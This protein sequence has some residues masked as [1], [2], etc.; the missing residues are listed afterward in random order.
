MPTPL[1]ILF[2]PISITVLVLYAALMGWEALAPA[3]KLPQVT[4]WKTKGLLA[5]TA[6]F[7][8]ASYLPLFWD[9][10]LASWQLFDLTSYGLVMGTL[11]GFVV[12]ELVLYAWHRTMHNSN[13]LWRGFHQMHHSAERLDAFG[14]FWMSPMDMIGFAFIGS[15]ALALIVG[16]PPQAATNILLIT[17]FLAIFQHMN[18]KTPHW[19]G[20]VIERP[21]SHN[22]HHARGLHAFNY[23]DL[24]LID[25]AFGT[26]RNPHAFEHE[27]G[28]YDGAS[29]RVLD[30][31][32]FQDVSEPKTVSTSLP[33]VR[34]NT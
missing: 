20:F 30:M 27:T 25:M 19:L 7:F 3:R 8:V 32:A 14:A 21:E 4:W 15:L 6:N 12:F 33:G 5:F 29:S 16:V 22:V 13:T 26:L 23:C 24:P 17:V 28:F 31:M 10:H 34:Q 18:V 2:D 9:Q 1:E 11:I